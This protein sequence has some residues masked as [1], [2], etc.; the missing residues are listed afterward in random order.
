MDL[1]I[2]ETFT[3][4]PYVTILSVIVMVIVPTIYLIIYGKRPVK[5]QFIT[6]FL[7]NA[8]FFGQ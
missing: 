7:L 5:T 8:L 3:C 1:N 6:L 2:L 4:R